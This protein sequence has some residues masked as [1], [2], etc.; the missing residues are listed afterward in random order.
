MTEADRRT[1]DR[2]EEIA[3]LS[4]IAAAQLL[5]EALVT[6]IETT[7][8][9]RRGLTENQKTVMV[10]AALLA[11]DGYRAR[12]LAQLNVDHQLREAVTGMGEPGTLEG[13]KPTV[14][15]GTTSAEAPS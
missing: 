13:W 14:V 10:E 5:A 2:L 12:V 6:T 7:G 15:P 4:T 1:R 3:S 8:D 11:F 9:G